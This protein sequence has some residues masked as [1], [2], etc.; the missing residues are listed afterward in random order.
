MTFFTITESVYNFQMGFQTP[1][2]P[3]AE[4]IFAF[5]DDLIIFI[6]G[7]LFFVRYIIYACLTQFSK[8]EKVVA[9]ITRPVY[10]GKNQIPHH[11]VHAP[12]LEI[13]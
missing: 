6:T 12:V 7:I 13:I 3:I 8:Q 11:F 5:H 1:V 9:N 2:T 10:V 4:G